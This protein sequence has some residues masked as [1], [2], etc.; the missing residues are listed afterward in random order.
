MGYYPA[1]KTIVVDGIFFNA[2]DTHME[3]LIAALKNTFEHE[4][5]PTAYNGRYPC[6]MC[7]NQNALTGVP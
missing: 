5:T 2:C 6:K 1:T 4:A 3:D 7:E